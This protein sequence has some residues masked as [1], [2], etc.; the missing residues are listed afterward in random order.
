MRIIWRSQVFR[1]ILSIAIT[2]FGI[3]VAVFL[4]L[5]AVPGDQISSQFGTEAAALTPK[6]KE[7]L[8]AYYGLDKPLIIQ[9]FTWL[10]GLFVGNLGYSSRTQE[11]VLEMTMNSLPVTA[12]LAV[13]TLLLAVVIG[14]PLGMLGASKAGSVRDW[15]SGFVSNTGLGIPTFLLGTALLAYSAQKWGFNPNGLPYAKFFDNP[16]L[17]LSQMLMPALVIAIGVAAPIIRTTRAAILEVQTLDFVKMAKAKGVPAKRLSRSHILRNALVPIVTMT[18]MQFGFLLGGAVVVEQIFSLPGL[19]RQ[20]LLAINQKE[21]SVVQSS[22]LV[23][24]I[25]FVL[26]NLATDWLYRVIDPRVRAE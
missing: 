1:R 2:L 15:I 5:R 3:A 23:I 7:S 17:N 18:G 24:A 21:Y 25:L 12:E 22:V 14:V 26:V 20:V 9:F 8:E 6:Q 19:G 16:I 10:G 13:L 4:M 11:S